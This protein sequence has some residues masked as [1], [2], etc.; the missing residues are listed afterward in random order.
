MGK[1]I[2]IAHQDLYEESNVKK[3]TE[4]IIDES[5]EGIKMTSKHLT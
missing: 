1:N 5:R 2:V 4:D 3:W